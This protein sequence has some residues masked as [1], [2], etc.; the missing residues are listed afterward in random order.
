MPLALDQMDRFELVMIGTNT[1]GIA[2]T[3]V[4]LWWTR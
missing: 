1:L 2:A 4:M 3:L